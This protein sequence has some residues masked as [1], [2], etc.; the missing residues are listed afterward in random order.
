MSSWLEDELGE[1]V[2]LPDRRHVRAQGRR[3]WSRTLRMLC[4]EEQGA[5]DLDRDRRLVEIVG[6]RGH[7]C[8]E[9]V[10]ECVPRTFQD[11]ESTAARG[12]QAGHLDRHVDAWRYGRIAADDQVKVVVGLTA[13]SI[14]EGM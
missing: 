2:D 13:G 8:A 7:A 11:R 10:L 6:R 3:P 12:R 5:L 1:R 9:K 14:E 4:V